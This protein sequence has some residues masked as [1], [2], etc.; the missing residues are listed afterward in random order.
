[1]AESR[2]LEI[3]AQETYPLRSLVLRNRDSGIPCSFDGDLDKTTHHF[4]YMLDNEVVSIVSFYE[5]ENENFGSKTMVQLRG[6]ATHPN[7]SGQG[8]GKEL[9]NFTIDCFRDKG[10]DLIWCNAREIAITFYEKL[11]FKSTGKK[12][13]IQNIGP[14]ILMYYQF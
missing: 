4:G 13:E 11:G 2:I 8:F 12:F 1:M 3:S 6:M 10:I 9:M 5:R 14:H 7:F